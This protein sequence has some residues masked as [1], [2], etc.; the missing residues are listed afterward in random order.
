MKSW[1][2]DSL[3]FAYA[4]K[5]K[6]RLHKLKLGKGK[7]KKSLK[8]RRKKRRKYYTSE[9]DSSS[10]DDTESSESDSDSETS[11]SSSTEVSSSTDDDK[12]RKRKRSKRDKHR[13]MK[14]D[15]R[16]ERK[17][18]RRDKKAKRKSRRLPIVFL[19]F[20]VVVLL[21]LSI[22]CLLIAC[23]NNLSCSKQMFLGLLPLLRISACFLWAD[24]FAF[25]LFTGHQIVLQ[26]VK[27]AAKRALKI[28]M[29]RLK[30]QIGNPKSWVSYAL[31]FCLFILVFIACTHVTVQL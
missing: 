10:D 3:F 5:D 24:F 17:R 21:Y 13:R 1:W 16:R 28:K 18:K 6:R 26:R 30:C 14:R 23:E 2:T 31:S 15:R 22:Y 19:H 12:H 4:D 25:L 8:Q 11:E 29:V 9:S 7:H 27:V 20:E